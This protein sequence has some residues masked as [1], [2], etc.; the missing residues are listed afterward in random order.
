MDIQVSS[1]HE[2]LLF[3]LSGR[4]GARTADLLTRFRGIGA[5]EAPHNDRFDAA[6]LDDDETLAVIRQV[7]DTTGCWSTAHRRRHRRRRTCW[8]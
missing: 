7:H 8:N 3:E 2:R 4:N 6:S 5:V 1:N